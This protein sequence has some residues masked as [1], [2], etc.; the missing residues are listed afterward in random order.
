LSD[1]VTN[2]F[3][4][5]FRDSIAQVRTQVKNTLSKDLQIELK[6]NL[7]QIEQGFSSKFEQ[8]R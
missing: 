2:D 5:K 1:S 3:E 8:L 7:N 4:N 6:Y